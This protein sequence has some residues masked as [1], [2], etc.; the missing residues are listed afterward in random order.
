ML[1]ATI[2]SAAPPIAHPARKSDASAFLVAAISL[3]GLILSA[4]VLAAAPAGTE[5][6]LLAAG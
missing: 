1:S 4:L 3:G 6:V 5:L 2:A